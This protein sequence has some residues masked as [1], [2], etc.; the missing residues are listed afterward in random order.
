[1]TSQ[2]PETSFLSFRPKAGSTSMQRLQGRFHRQGKGDRRR[3]RRREWCGRA[4]RRWR[5]RGGEKNM[6]IEARG[7]YICEPW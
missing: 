3:Q 1:L 5:W 2:P 7:A 6:R 4:A